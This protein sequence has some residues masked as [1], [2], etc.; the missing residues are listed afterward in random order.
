LQCKIEKNNKT[1]TKGSKQKIKN[2]KI[3]T[4]VKIPITMRVSHNF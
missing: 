3:M 1:S 4:E 2:E